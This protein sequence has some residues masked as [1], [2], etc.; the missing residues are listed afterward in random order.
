MLIANTGQ[1]LVIMN[2][3][4]GEQVQLPPGQTTPVA[5]SKISFIDD[6]AVL[7]SLFNS[8]VLVAYTDAGN[9]LTGFPTAASVRESRTLPSVTETAGAATLNAAPG[10]RRF[11]RRVL[12]RCLTGRSNAVALSNALFPANSNT[13][14]VTLRYRMGMAADFDSVRVIIPNMHTSAQAGVKAA[15][16]VSAA[17]GGWATTA[18]TAN[19]AGAATA[20]APTNTEAVS[21]AGAALIQATFDGAATATL[22]AAIDAANQCPSWSAS[23]WVPIKSLARSDGGVFPLLDLVLFFPASGTASMA[24]TGA[25]NSAWALWGRDDMF[26][27]GRVWRVWMNDGD[28]I[29][30]PANF[31]NAT[32]SAAFVPVIIQYRSKTKGVSIV[33]FGDSI[34]DAHN[35]TYPG[36]GFAWQAALAMSSAARPV[37]LCS[38]CAPGATTLQEMI[39]AESV[40]PLLKPSVM[41]VQCAS[42]NSFGTSLGSRTQQ[43]GE[44]TVGTALAL[45]AEHGSALVV[46]SMLPVTA[47]GKPWGA[48]DSQRVALNAALNARDDDYTFINFSPYV[49]GVINSGQ[50][51]PLATLIQGDG[52]H[53]NDTGH[54]VMATPFREGVEQSLRQAFL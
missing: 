9:T 17:L 27:A 54:T 36:N 15:F 23:D 49:D 19:N 11:Q 44:G 3:R 35:V 41:A 31:T 38:M 22:P 10:S 46:G 26:S 4:T 40:M 2:L 7:I 34:W 21:G 47:G 43:H 25:S 42:L 50:V 30:T 16:G 33:T 28:C 5:D 51:E 32:T 53:F 45:A 24:Y 14:G 37:E 6:S 18:P 13:N 48:T 52:Q 1:S 29:A 39:R 20:A 12:S 8:G